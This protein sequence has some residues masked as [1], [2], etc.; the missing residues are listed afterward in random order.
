MKLSG[1]GV[2]FG[3]KMSHYECSSFHGSKT[4]QVFCLL[5][6]SSGEVNFNP[7]IC[8]FHPHSHVGMKLLFTDSVSSQLLGR[9]CMCNY[10]FIPIFFFVPHLLLLLSDTSTDLS[11][12]SPGPDGLVLFV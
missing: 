8:Q 5:G 1:P 9:G 10:V 12:L 2:F 3:G 11:V 7:G 4:I 6:S